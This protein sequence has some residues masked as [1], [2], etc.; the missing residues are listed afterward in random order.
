MLL[1]LNINSDTI[2]TE[3]K[4]WSPKGALIEAID[5]KQGRNN[6]YVADLYYH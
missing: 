3:V 2:D 5:T 4:V 1:R 6:M